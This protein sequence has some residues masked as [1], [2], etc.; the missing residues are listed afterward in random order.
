[1]RV[2]HTESSVNWGGQEYRAL[3]QMG[4]LREHGHQAF[5][6]ARPGSDIGARA[7]LAGFTVFEVPFTGHYDPRSILALRR[8]I[9]RH[10]IEIADCHGSRDVMT[11]SFARNLIPV[12]RTRHVSQAIKNK[13]HRRLQWRYGSDHIIATADC[14]R[15]EILGK[16][17]APAAQVTVVGE[18]A[19]VPFFDVGEKSAHRS[20]VRQEFQVPDDKALVLVVGMLRGDKA[21]EVLIETVAELRQ[22]GRDVVALIVG[23]V[24]HS[25]SDYGRKLEDLAA[26]LAVEDLVRFAGYRDDVPRLTQGCD[27]QVIT[28]ISVEA[29]SR[30]VPQAFASRTPVVASRVG[31][32]AELVDH[33]KTGWLVPPQ[34][35]SAYADALI[36]LL[37]NSSQ[38]ASVV[39]EA[40]HF[41]ERHLRMDQ[42]MVQTLDLYRQLIDAHASVSSRP[43]S[44][45]A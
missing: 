13:L 9:K 2:L 12:I 31:G 25:Q 20:A 27:A 37:E 14:I 45:A 5:L 43:R 10:G 32:I 26:A 8:L 44:G 7:R 42:K 38:T 4:W 33:G 18:W 11:L 34:D 23:S 22:R 39:E 40:R 19:G 21:Q 17:L 30:T 29:Q 41:A 1:M 28:S 3:E 36:R 16:F 24:T 35:V 15:D 6:A